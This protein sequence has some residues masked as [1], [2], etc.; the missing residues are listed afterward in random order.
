MSDLILEINL[1][2]REMQRLPWWQA[3]RT[4][5]GLIVWKQF[6]PPSTRPGQKIWI[7]T[8]YFIPTDQIITALQIAVSNGVEVKMILPGKSDSHVVKARVIV[9]HKPFASEWYQDLFL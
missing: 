2:A 9:L 1:N 3:A 7:V 5:L 4:H 6:L 8:P